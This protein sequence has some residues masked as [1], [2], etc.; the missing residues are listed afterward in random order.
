MTS[1]KGGILASGDLLQLERSQQVESRMVFRCRDGSLYDETV[2]FT[3]DQNFTL[4]NYH[5]VQ[6]GPAFDTDTE[7]S[8]E[9]SS[10]KYRVSTE[11]HNDGRKQVLNGTLDLPLDVYNGMVIMVAKNFPKGATKTIHVVAFTPKPRVIQLECAP[12]GEHENAKKLQS[13]MC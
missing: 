5:L 8:L 6:R 2:R 11:A 4:Q 7:V 9:R 1:V 12:E 3:R 13:A 10:G